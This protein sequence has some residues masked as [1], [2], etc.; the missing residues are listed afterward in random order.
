MVGVCLLDSVDDNFLAVSVGLGD[1]LLTI[2]D[3]G[4]NIFDILHGPLA[5]ET[6][7]NCC[8]FEHIAYI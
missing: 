8:D 1:D 3:L 2:F 6:G 4:G 5:R 7:C